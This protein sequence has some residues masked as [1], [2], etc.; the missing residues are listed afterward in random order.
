[1][2]DG[3]RELAIEIA[4]RGDAPVFLVSSMSNALVSFQLPDGVIPEGDV[5]RVV[6]GLAEQHPPTDVELCERFIAGCREPTG[7]LR[8]EALHYCWQFLDLF[9]GSKPLKAFVD[10]GILPALPTR[11]P[12]RGS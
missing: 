7:E 3:I 2:S 11:L 1:M 8:M 5:R 10:A 12:A 6:A 4:E 9:A